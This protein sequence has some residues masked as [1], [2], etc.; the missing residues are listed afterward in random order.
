VFQLLVWV[1]KAGV[2]RPERVRC[3][4]LWELETQLA[5]HG[6]TIPFPQRDLHLRSGFIRELP[7]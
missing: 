1:S 2:R 3:A 6:I 7:D 4:I 5:E